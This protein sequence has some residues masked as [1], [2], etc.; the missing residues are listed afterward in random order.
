MASGYVVEATE[1]TMIGFHI[2]RGRRTIVLGFLVLGVAGAL[3]L[4]ARRAGAEGPAAA[5]ATDVAALREQRIKTL[6]T[7]ADMAR[8]M[9]GQGTVEFAEVLRIDRS[10][11][12]AQLESAATDQARV[13]ILKKALGVA[14]QLEDLASAR[15]RA[16]VGTPLATLEATAERLRVEVRLAEL[17]AK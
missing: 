15:N 7:A 16:G 8:Q 9:Y 4:E 14:R 1:A 5:P 3:L 11:L 6:R 12:D 17:T 10:L 2:L 13:E